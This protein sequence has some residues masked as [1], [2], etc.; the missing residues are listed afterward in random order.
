M[1]QIALLKIMSLDPHN[2]VLCLGFGENIIMP[3][4]ANNEQANANLLTAC[5]DMPIGIEL[6]SIEDGV[7]VAS[8][9]WSNK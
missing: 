3:V 7:A 1:K 4:T 2:Q 6:E 8:K 9:V 5:I